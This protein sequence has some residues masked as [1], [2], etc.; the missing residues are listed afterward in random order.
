MS[1]KTFLWVRG[2]PLRAALL[3]LLLPFPVL[4]QVEPDTVPVTLTGTV[5][6]AATR[7]PLR[8]VILRLPDLALTR[9]SDEEG[10]FGPIQIP[11]GVYRL[12]LSR[13]GYQVAEGD[14][15]VRQGGSFVF[16][17]SPLDAAG[18]AEPSRVRGQV[19]DEATGEPLAT[20][21][22]SFANTDLIRLTDEEGRFEFPRVPAGVRRLKVEHLGY[23]LREDSV[24]IPAG[25]VV[26]LQVRLGVLP[27]P[28]EGITVAV[29]ARDRFLETGGFYRRK[30][31]GLG[32]QWT[33]EEIAERNTLFLTDLIRGV[34]GLQLEWQ[35]GGWAVYSRRRASFPSN[36]AA[37]MPDR[38][39]L[40]V[41]VDGMQMV[42]FDLDSLDPM[43]IEAFE[44]YH[45]ISQTPI[46]YSHLCGVILVWL[47]Y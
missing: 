25:R 13:L 28:L 47:R 17:L 11:R 32:R 45:G 37:P 3:A 19:T 23:G 9:I 20:A 44:V 2:L 33:R 14:F 34:P 21:T 31:R 22:V 46:E 12:S 15:T 16:E 8:N 42:D 10:G 29:E 7:E 1:A 26:D 39:E 18:S 41:Y 6:D 36:A 43:S 40:A 27:I 35:P 5:V 24:L 38:C 4:S 30:E